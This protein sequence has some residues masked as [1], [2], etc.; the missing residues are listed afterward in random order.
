MKSERLGL[1]IEIEIVAESLAGFGTIAL[2]IGFWRTEQT[3]AHQN[4]GISGNGSL[5]PE[6][7]MR[8]SSAQR[9]SSGN[10]LPGFSSPFSSKAHLTRCCALR[11]ISENITP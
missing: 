3:E 6:I 2:G 7:C 4:L 11:S 1:D 9:C 10:T 5:P 8:P